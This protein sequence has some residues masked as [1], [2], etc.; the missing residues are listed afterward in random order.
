[1]EDRKIEL[2]IPLVKQKSKELC[3]E[4]SAEMIMKFLG[5]ET[6][7]SFQE[8]LER[9]GCDSLEKMDKCLVESLVGI[10]CEVS[11][12]DI[13]TL[14]KNLSKG[15][16]TA[17]RIIPEHQK[18]KHTVVLKAID[19]N[20]IIVN[21]PAQDSPVTYSKHDFLKL[22][23]KTDNLMLSCEKKE[24][25]ECE[26]CN[27]TVAASMAETVC[28]LLGENDKKQCKDIFSDI[29]KGGQSLK[30]G[31]DKVEEK[32]KRSLELLDEI[33]KIASE[34]GVLDKSANPQ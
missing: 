7:S 18:A 2:E 22:W 26:D 17:L 16:P 29:K 5:K 21:D 9:S 24:I 23:G 19:N 33:K 10:N 13:N 34:K 4:A 20:N 6:S 25:E 8:D 11:K 27:F 1:L 31:L 32:F 3:S 15:I 14:E 28:D 30:D 12:G